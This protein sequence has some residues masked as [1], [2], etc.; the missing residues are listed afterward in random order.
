MAAKKRSPG[1]KW[2]W[3]SCDRDAE[4]D[5]DN[6]P[7]M[8]RRTRIWELGYVTMGFCVLKFNFCCKNYSWIAL[9]TEFS[10][11]NSLFSSII[12][13]QNGVFSHMRT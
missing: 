8:R 1:F 13:C 3:I 10:L 11:H 12:G 9:K 5:A 2:V 7:G 6:I 4:T